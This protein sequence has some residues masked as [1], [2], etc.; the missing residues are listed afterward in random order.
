MNNFDSYAAGWYT[1]S[2]RSRNLLK[3]VILSGTSPPKITASRL[4]D[5]SMENF[6]KV[7]S[8]ECCFDFFLN[9]K[10]RTFHCRSCRLQFRTLPF[11]RRYDRLWRGRNAKTSLY[12]N[13]RAFSREYAAKLYSYLSDKSEH[14]L[15]LLSVRKQRFSCF[16][17]TL[18]RRS[19]TDLEFGV[20]NVNTG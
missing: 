14:F 3:I 8:C 9:T 15:L 6:A 1:L 18:S 16:S 20:F 11:W 19:V 17:N 13:E 10:W 2:L 12:A 4:Y 7:R 5:V